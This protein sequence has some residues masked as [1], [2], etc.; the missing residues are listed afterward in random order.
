MKLLK[1]ELMRLAAF[2]LMAITFV[3]CIKDELP[4]VE[5]DI[6]DIE[7]SGDANNKVLKTKIGLEEITI[8]VNP[9]LDVSNVI[10][11]YTLSEGAR[12]VEGGDVTDFTT[13]QNIKVLSEDGNWSKIYRVT[14]AAMKLPTEYYYEFWKQ[15]NPNKKYEECFE[16]I[17]NGYGEIVDFD[18]WASGNAG[19]AILASKNAPQETY[20]TYKETASAHSGYSAGM[21]TKYIGAAGMGSP[22]AAGSLFIGEFSTD[23]DE[24]GGVMKN[25]RLATR[26]GLPFNKKPKTFKFCFKYKSAGAMHDYDLI[27]GEDLGE[28]EDPDTGDKRDYCAAYA[29]LF[30]NVKAARLDYKGRNYLDGNN[31]LSSEAEVARAILTDDNKYGT[32]GDGYVSMEI[33]FTYTENIDPARLANYEYSLAIVFSSSYHGA[34]FK[35]CP[36]SKMWVDNVIIECE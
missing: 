30:D 22:I 29:I 17:D 3:G 8:F 33:P 11:L 14:L 10:P 24:P 19:Y 28:Y 31:I 15:K 36:G 35:G 32:V 13:P 23:I 5:A 34:Y 21:Q 2:M 20:P 1:N 7:L 6:L 18:M 16:R 27:S 26:F 25:Q 12:I 9:S 4:N